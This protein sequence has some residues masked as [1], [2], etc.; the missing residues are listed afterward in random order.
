VESCRL[1]SIHHA[2]V[3]VS[4]VAY[5][6]SQTRIR[7]QSFLRYNLDALLLVWSLHLQEGRVAEEDRGLATRNRA[8]VENY[9]VDGRTQKKQ[10]LFVDLLS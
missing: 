9:V 1:Q 3:G 6:E 8:I 10:V 7:L 5:S 4:L 2:V